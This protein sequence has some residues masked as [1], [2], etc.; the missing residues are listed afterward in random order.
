MSKWTRR[1]HRKMR[2]L[3]ITRLLKRDGDECHLCGKKLDRKLKD[4][5]DPMYI[6]FDHLQPT[7]KGGVTLLENLK[8]AHRK[9]NEERGNEDIDLTGEGF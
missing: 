2:G 7:S 9:C 1:N 3:N 6:T 8:L 5:F 4:E